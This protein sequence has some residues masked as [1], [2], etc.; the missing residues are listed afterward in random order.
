MEKPEPAGVKM[1]KKN[2]CLVNI[3]SGEIHNLYKEENHKLLEYYLLQK[4]K[5][6]K[7]NFL[8]AFRLG[9]SVSE[10]DLIVEYVSGGEAFMH[11]CSL[12]W[13]F[14]FATVPPSSI[15]GGKLAFIIALTYIGIVTAVVGEFATILGC[16]LGIDDS[17]TAITLVA[18]GTSLPDTFASMAAARNSQYADSAIG[19]VTGSN[20]VNVFLGLG[21]PWVIAVSYYQKNMKDSNGDMIPYRVPAGEIA[22]SVFVFLIVAC[23]CFM[24]LIGRRI[25][26]GGELGGPYKSKVASCA[27]LVFL[28]VVYIIMS[29]LNATAGPATVPD[30]NTVNLIGMAPSAGSIDLSAGPISDSKTLMWTGCSILFGISLYC[31]N[32]RKS[33]INSDDDYQAI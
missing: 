6:Y 30:A 9:P 18:L 33:K 4:E 31:L 3:V 20:S 14:L 23:I 16:V 11:F 8:N 12:F 28:W 17:I 24:V 13:K 32:T 29:I 25:I 2:L 10:D 5:S 26:I 15:W 21:L 19:N 22:Y 27:F 1:S 7:N